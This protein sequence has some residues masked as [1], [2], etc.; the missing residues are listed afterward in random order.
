MLLTYMRTTLLVRSALLATT[1]FTLYPTTS[2]NLYATAPAAAP[3]FVAVQAPFGIAQ[4][5]GLSSLRT[6]QLLQNLS[7][8]TAVTHGA[9]MLDCSLACSAQML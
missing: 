6:I 1:V 3:G 4:L 5:S 9:D 7:R 2:Y 8:A